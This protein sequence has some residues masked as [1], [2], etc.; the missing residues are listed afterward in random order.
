MDTILISERQD[1]YYNNIVEVL[2]K[3]Y[4]IQTCEYSTK[5]ITRAV[6]IVKPKVLIY[7][8]DISTP[9]LTLRE[10]SDEITQVPIIAVL[11]EDDDSLKK[12]PVV[13]VRCLQRPFKINRLLYEISVA[14]SSIKYVETIKPN[15]LAVDDNGV[16]LRNIKQVIGT[17]Y[18]VG[19]ATNGERALEMLDEKEYDLILL[20]YE[21]PGMSG[22]EVFLEL[23]NNKQYKHIPVI[24]LT[25]VSDKVRVMEIVMNKP[26]GYLLKPIDSDKL[27]STIKSALENAKE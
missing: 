19:M 13:N 20:D 24:F 10:L 14:V 5:A 25:S 2:S 15:I 7:F 12:T 17:E 4:N 21:M 27:I 16:I 1:G 9:P 8:K 22:Y 3:D 23:K 11:D 18:N 6:K 26:A